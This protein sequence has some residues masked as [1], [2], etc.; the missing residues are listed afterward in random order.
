[1]SQ[2]QF[3]NLL[4]KKLTGEAGEE[5][6][7]QL[8]QLM[9][10][11]P[12]LLYAAQHIEDLWNLKSLSTGNKD[13]EAAFNRHLKK[14]S[15]I[16]LEKEQIT[17]R[18]LIKPKSW[19]SL[20]TKFKWIPI[21]VFSSVGLFLIVFLFSKQSV[22]KNINRYSE[23]STK[24]GSRSKL[25]LPDSSTVW[26][27]AGSKLTYNSNFGATD[28]SVHLTGE[29]FFDVKK[30]GLPFIIHTGAIQIKVLGTAFNVKSYPS[31][32]TI[33]TT[34]IRGVVEITMD[35]RPEKK[36]TLYPNEKLVLVN[37]TDERLKKKAAEDLLPLAVITPIALTKD[38]TIIE[39]SWKDNKLIFQNEAFDELARQMERWYGV[40][41][42]FKNNNVKK[43]RFTG[44]FEK[45][46]I[47][48][49]LE[50][51]KYTSEFNYNMEDN[52]IT[53]Q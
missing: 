43:I 4:A 30:T 26:L 48:Q 19:F 46:T 39:T 37:E 51:L 32:K 47:E 3:W 52:L 31:E 16:L 21:A 22:P 13:E 5:D 33:E 49:A 45:E 6:L 38:S 18:Q 8:H 35:K 41:I 29:A 9:K 7:E 2:H 34:L 24:P 15:G 11:N 20:V 36:F 14:L 53:I 27:N 50:A 42:L 10:L 40:N 25:L 17:K 12:E 28:R 44:V 1:M 23:I